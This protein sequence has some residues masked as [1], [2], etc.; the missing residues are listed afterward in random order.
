MK[1]DRVK[2]AGA[3]ETITTTL[4]DGIKSGD[5]ESWTRLKDLYAPL[6]LYWCRRSGLDEADRLD[7]SQ[8]VFRS[9]V[10]GVSNFRRDRPGDTFRGWLRTITKKELANHW[11][12]KTRRP[13]QLHMPESF[14][15]GWSSEEDSD[16]QE[17]AIL[18][19]QI[20][21]TVEGWLTQVNWKAFYAVTVE[22]R[23]PAEVAEELSITRNQIFITKARTLKR[24]RA[25]FGDVFNE[26][27]GVT[28][29]STT[30]V[31]D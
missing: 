3:F 28:E 11:R 13:D 9:V 24:I 21:R 6:V 2:L 17:A 14:E 12:Q 5:D 4:L 23:V 8:D 7:V 19:E 15:P 26:L 29:E 1:D 31:P 30:P 10:R 22:E 16:S 27:F 18:V 25:E 20:L